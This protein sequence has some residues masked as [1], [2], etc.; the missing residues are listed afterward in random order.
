MTKRLETSRRAL[1]EAG[2]LQATM[3]ALVASPGPKLHVAVVGA[4][5]FG[6]WSALQ[7]LRQGARVTL[8]DAWGPGNSRASSGGETR[9]LR[10]SYG[11]DRVYTLMAA[12]AI[13]LWRENDARWKL[14]LFHRTGVLRLPG[15]DDRYEKASARLLREAG[16]AAEEIDRK[17]AEKRW[18]Q[19][20]FDRVSWVLYEPDAGYLTA[21]RACE[22]VLAGFLQEGGE[23]RQLAVKPMTIRA[24][25]MREIA[26]SDGS[27]L[28]ADQ[29]V[30]ACGPWLGRVFPDVIGDRVRTGRQEVFFFGTPAGD[31]LF[32]EER[33]PV[34]IDN[35]LPHFYGI[36]GN[37]WRGFKI[38]YKAPDDAP[39]I[40]STRP[41]AIGSRLRS[42]FPWSATTCIPT[43][44]RCAALRW[45][46]RGCAS[47]R[48][49][50]ITTSF[51][52]AIRAPG[53]SG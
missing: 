51:S 32:F 7:L 52:T 26:L 35:G 18:P 4:G 33:L 6:G 10:A 34:W 42:A 47:T 8:L 25:E 12:R 40:P 24:G 31:P 17:E 3:P 27:K 39:L 21:R 20:H 9:I 45:S 50:P 15:P 36:P 41:P 44:R 14:R 1:L 49:A 46:R 2:L 43:F 5:A 13:Q 23:Y 22:A 28:S 11:A 48:T 30:F 16:L 29:Y 37:D 19:F 53:M 38:V